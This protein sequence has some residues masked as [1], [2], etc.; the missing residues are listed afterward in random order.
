MVGGRRS[1]VILLAFAALLAAA[2]AT[3]AAPSPRCVVG[4][5]DDLGCARGFD[6]RESDPRGPFRWTNG[7][8]A[9][10]LAGAGYGPPPIVELVLA[11]PRPDGSPPPRTV[12]AAGRSAVVLAPA[13]APRRYRLLASGPGG[14]A[15]G[16]TIA[17]ET[18]SP[19]GRRT[20]GVQVYQARAVLP[21]GPRLPAA[22]PTLSLLALGLAASLL[23]RDHRP[24]WERAIVPCLAI[25]GAAVL[26]VWLPGRVVPY[27]PALALIVGGAAVVAS[28][29]GGSALL[30]RPPVAAAVAGGAALDAAIVAQAI[31]RELIVL[32]LAAQAALVV[33]AVWAT[34]ERRSGM[35]DRRSN[36][37]DSLPQ[38][39]NSDL[40]SPI[41]NLA[42]VLFVA[43]AVRLL[44]MAARLLAAQAASDP[45]TGLFY[46]YGRAALEIGVPIVEYP[47]GALIPWMLLALPGSR[48]LFGLLLPLLNLACDLAIVWG[49]WKIGDWRSEIHAGAARSPISSLQTLFPLFYALSPLLLP[50]W[51]AKYDPLPAALL[52]LGLAAFAA[53]RP[54]WAGA[55]LGLGGAVKWV[56]WLA[57][58]FLAWHLL[59]SRPPT[60]DDRPGGSAR[61]VSVVGGRRSLVSAGRFL[62]G[63]A[64]AVTAAS[65]PFALRDWEAFLA[66]YRLQGGRPLIGESLWFPLAALMRPSLL[67]TIGV[68]WSGVRGSPLPAWA[69]VGS[70]LLVLGALG[71]A[72]LLFPVERRRTVALAALAPV[73]FLL[74]NRVFSP[75]YML[76][77]TACA[78]AAAAASWRER[79]ATPLLALLALAQAA[80][81]LVWPNTAP[82]WLVASLV[83]FAAA[84]AA[85]GWLLAGVLRPDVRRA[86]ALLAGALVAVPL[87]SLPPRPAEAAGAVRCVSLGGGPTTA[88]CANS[89]AFTSIQ[90]A[91]NAAAS[92]DELRIAAG[93]Y[94]GAGE[95]VVRIDGL[96]LTLRGGYDPSDWAT[97]RLAA[98]T[99]IDGQGA[100]RGVLAT[101]DV[102]LRLADL[103]VAR[104][105]AQFGGGVAVVGSV[106][107]LPGQPVPPS[108]AE[109]FLEEV[110]LEGNTAYLTDGD[111]ANKLTSGLGGGVFSAGRL[112]LAG[113]LVRGNTGGS[114]GGGLLAFGPVEIVSSRLIGNRAGDDGG[115]LYSYDA[116][117]AI[118]GSL[119]A[120]NRAG[121]VDATGEGDGVYVR[122]REGS[123]GGATT[124]VNVTIA[125]AE[126]APRAAIRFNRVVA[127]GDPMVLTLT[128][129]AVAGHAIG[130]ERSAGTTLQGDYNAFFGNQDDQR[131]GGVDAALPFAHL[132]SGDPRFAD[133]AAGDY[134]LRA[135]SPLVSAGDPGRSYTGQRDFELDPVPLGGRADIGADEYVA[136]RVLL[137]RVAR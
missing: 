57:A 90:A 12:V 127:A 70:Q 3:W 15:L 48:E 65:L 133:A 7:A 44:G 128:N 54:G 103:A 120:N 91:V 76:I 46:A 86:A 45:D 64:L 101:G 132:V 17:G 111:I 58:P 42:S 79:P 16:I 51:H 47:S 125:S 30:L 126:Q 124:L 28:R 95:S 73:L 34:C 10:R 6:L 25:G 60:T 71:L 100:R 36:T 72:Q 131:V 119:I 53:G 39:H 98:P 84:L 43:L 52:V 50:F 29:A 63:F 38:S 61:M 109:L 89:A 106:V 59:R 81:L 32:A 137:P 136:A 107:V 66:P 23:V 1:V 37:G 80:N 4:E 123:Q 117:V 129:T 18:F 49:I 8:A 33:W 5:E 105:F 85:V 35:G 116:N 83:M 99:V 93:T 9:V 68:P 94:T 118:T 22:L 41:S 115:G 26:W 121:T 20:L 122:N 24:A 27:L 135:E 88:P 74:L 82:Y 113:S 134:H 14:E 69:L 114:D 112:A 108:A 21:A 67:E 13:P 130:V 102:T 87:A 97:P 75:Q 40:G 110:V 96:S 92:G 11:A 104:G 31:P 2:A 19:G 55:A 56:P 62:L 78:L 77:V